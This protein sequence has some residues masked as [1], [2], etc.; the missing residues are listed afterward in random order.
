[1]AQ[2]QKDRSAKMPGRHTWQVSG[3]PADRTAEMSARHGWPV[4]EMPEDCHAEVPAAD[5]WPVAK[6]QARRSRPDDAAAAI[7]TIGKTATIEATV[8]A[9]Q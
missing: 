8:A 9:E 5:G 2:L 6:L 7:T 1:M 4:A 3:M